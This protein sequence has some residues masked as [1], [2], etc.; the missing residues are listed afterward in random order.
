MIQTNFEAN[1][2]ETTPCGW[3]LIRDQ[4]RMV[5][6]INRQA[7]FARRHRSLDWLMNYKVFEIILS[8][9]IKVGTIWSF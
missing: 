9:S 2:R 4:T 8:T 7:A 6:R 5:A 3:L 1:R